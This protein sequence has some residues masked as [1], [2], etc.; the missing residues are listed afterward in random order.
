M[1]VGKGKMFKPLS[2]ARKACSGRSPAA[3]WIPIIPVPQDAPPPP[4]THFKYDAPTAVHAYRGPDRQTWGYVCRFDL[5]DGSKEFWPLTFCRK[6]RVDDPEWRWKGF[7][8]PRP[9]YNLDRLSAA[10][11]ETSIVV[12][13]GEKAADAAGELLPGW[14][15]TTSPGGSNAARR[16]DWIATTGHPVVI[17]PDADVAG[18]KYA[19]E[20]ASMV[21]K[22][23]AAPVAIVTPP[24]GVKAGWDAGDAL[25]EGWTPEQALA[26]VEAARPAAEFKREIEATRSGPSSDGGSRGNETESVGGSGDGGGG[27]TNI[28]G[29]N[30][31]GDG[32]GA[33]DGRRRRPPQRDNLIA[34]VDDCELWHCQDSEAYA[35]IPVN[36]H[37]ENLE[38][39]T[40]DFK[41]WLGWRY[42]KQIGGTVG[43]QAIDDAIRVME[44]IAVNEGFCHMPRRRVGEKAGKLYLDLADAAWRAVETTGDG[45]RVIDRPPVKFVRSSGMRPLPAPEA[46]GMIEELKSFVN[47]ARE[48]DFRMLVSW[49]VCAFR[50]NRP[51]PML[52]ISG[53]Q[54]SAKS[55]SCRV[56]RALVDPNGAAIRGAPKDERDLVIAAHNSWVFALDNQSG[57]PNWLSDS[58]CRLATGG[59]QATRALHTDRN[60]T[61]FEAMRPIMIN[62]IPDLA[63]RPD[64][65]ERAIA[66]S[67]SAIIETER[68]TE[69]EF[70]SEFEAARPSILG[71]LLDA[72]SSALRHRP[73]VKIERRPRMAD[74]GEWMTAAEPGLGWDPGSFMDAYEENQ[75]QV[76]AGAME[77]SPVALAVQAFITE[78]EPDGWDGTPTEL[79]GLLAG[80]VS[81]TVQKSK[82][83]PGNAR[84]LGIAITRVAPILRSIGIDVVRHKGGRDSKRM[85]SIKPR[86][87]K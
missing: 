80:K 81:E 39:R 25:V 24:E 49:L 27:Q 66:V 28:G 77:A 74:F 14:V 65:G 62:G 2:G 61:I 36:G 83:W 48:A 10:T 54:G 75:K 41:R 55:T 21:A 45:W 29:G 43:G 60:E 68:R 32:G 63:S 86:V 17:W 13:E 71:A 37:F 20:V 8:I 69:D 31:A 30:G 7:D 16:A 5:E 26:L 78:N 67:L 9:L 12:C 53:E 11:K 18:Q 40:R 50:A 46:G 79:L 58:L 6:L 57:I 72:V 35:T 51:F 4:K 23:G 38:I 85:I 19:A 59:G 70:Y 64:L 44:G 1:V 52:I 22:A 73:G 15:A 47:V 42:Y 3:G 76:V 33:G 84:S 34:L 87:N 82:Q 56:M